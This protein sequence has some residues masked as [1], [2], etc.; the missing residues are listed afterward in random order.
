[1]S[2]PK[3]HLFFWQKRKIEKLYEKKAEEFTLEGYQ[4]IKIEDIKAYFQNYLWKDRSVSYR[5]MKKEIADLKTSDYF[6]YQQIEKTIK[7]P[8][9]IEE[10]D[11]EKLLR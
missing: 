5:K 3:K 6:D 9:P 4:N 7:H 1:M 8:K 11:L 10:L 2:T